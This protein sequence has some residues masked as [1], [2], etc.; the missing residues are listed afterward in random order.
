MLEQGIFFV[1]WTTSWQSWEH[2]FKTTLWLPWLT[3]GKSIQW[4]RRSGRLHF[5]SPLTLLSRFLR[6]LVRFF[7]DSPPSFLSSTIWMKTSPFPS[8]HPQLMPQFSLLLSLLPSSFTRF[9]FLL[10]FFFFFPLLG[11]S[12]LIFVLPLS[13]RGWLIFAHFLAMPQYPF[14]NNVLVDLLLGWKNLFPLP[15]PVNWYLFVSYVGFYAGVWFLLN[16]IDVSIPIFVFI[17]FYNTWI[18]YSTCLYYY[19]NLLL[20]ILQI[21]K[22]KFV[23]FAW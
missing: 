2:S 8:L 21:V 9:F 13:E 1:R 5:S 20:S 3:L 10:S 22:C 19:Q 7:V 6:Y 15:C 12:L 18:R 17:D 23:S 4:P 11:R 16:F 14:E